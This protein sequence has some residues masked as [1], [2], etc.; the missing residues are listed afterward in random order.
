MTPA[1]IW[2]LV[3]VVL[4]GAEFVSGELFL[5]MLGGGA[6]A[7]AGGAALGLGLL[8][9][10]GLFAIVSVLL[11]LAVRPVAKRKL[12]ERMG[13][14]ERHQDRFVGSAAEVVQ[15]VDGEGGQVRIGKEVWSARSMDGREVLEAGT[16]VTVLQVTGAAVLV[17]GRGELPAS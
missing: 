7:A 5:V 14:L 3:G 6:L 8:P 9:S 11:L 12:Q 1:L 15:R 16:T 17:T 10:A 4:V 13:S 2:L